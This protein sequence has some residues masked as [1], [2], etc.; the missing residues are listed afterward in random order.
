MGDRVTNRAHD[1]LVAVVIPCYKVR[2]QILN[3]LGSIGPE[4]Q[5][6]YVVDDCCPD[7][8]GDLVELECSDKRVRVLRNQQNQGVG[9]A[10]ITGYKKALDDGS[11]VIVKID[12]DG[13][14]D[15]SLIEDFLQPIYSGEADYTKGNRFFDPESLRGMPLIRIIGN[16]A[17]SFMNKFSSGYWSIFDPTNGYTAIHASVAR[18]LPLHKISKRYFFETDMLFRLNLIRAVV[19]DIPMVSHY[20]GEKSN[21]R[22][23]KV[24]PEFAIKH[25]RN[26]FKR[27]FYCYILR[28]MSVASIE[29]P[30]GVGLISFGCIFGVYKWYEAISNHVVNSSG[31]VMLAALPIIM[32]TQLILGFLAYDIT[33]VPSRPI[34]KINKLSDN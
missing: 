22:I 16:A 4:V 15:P 3:V 25:I 29:F 9:G 24:L 23:S 27:Y 30:L 18:R 13:Q 34:S 12:G 10:L 7:G 6:I 26:F 17:L 31:T 11:D 21:L 19:V 8:S 5:S 33:N 32:G 20:H 2:P 14:M 28:D 1:W